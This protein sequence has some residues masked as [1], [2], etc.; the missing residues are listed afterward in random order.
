[1]GKGGCGLKWDMV[2]SEA[3]EKNMQI[4]DYKDKDRFQRWDKD[5]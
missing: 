3:G 5:G 4:N 1:M 2:D